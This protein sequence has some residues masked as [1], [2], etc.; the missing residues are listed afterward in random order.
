MTSIHKHYDTLLNHELAF[1]DHV[2]D[3]NELYLQARLYGV[4]LAGD[5]RI[6]RAVE[7][8]ARAVIESRDCAV[9]LK[10]AAGHAPHIA[11]NAALATK[12]VV[13]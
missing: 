6:E 2:F 11:L 10:I 5:D 8:L 3:A 4:P 7:A 13:S 12:R 9:L 1:V